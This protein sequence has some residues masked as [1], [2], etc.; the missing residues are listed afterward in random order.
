MIE[1]PRTVGSPIVSKT[2]EAREKARNTERAKWLAITRAAR[3]KRAEATRKPARAT[4]EHTGSV[5]LQPTFLDTTIYT[6]LLEVLTAE[7]FA[8]NILGRM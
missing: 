3:M 5:L 4:D 2:V 8:A 7:D 1:I 6:P